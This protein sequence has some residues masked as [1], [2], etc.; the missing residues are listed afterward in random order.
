MKLKWK[1][2]LPVLALLLI[3]TLLTTLLNYSMTKSTV[4]KIVDSIVDSNLDTLNQMMNHA[5]DTEKAVSSELDSKNLALTR[6]FAEIVRLRAQRGGIDF[7]DTTLFQNIADMLGVDE[8]HVM[9]D[10]GVIV[11]SNVGIYYG[12]D[13]HSG[14]QT[15]PFLRILD[16]PSYELAQEPQPNASY[17]SLF[18]YTGVARTDEKGIVQVGIGA[19]MIEKLHNYLDIANT[20]AGMRIGSTG[21][22]VIIE[23]GTVMYSHKKDLIGLDVSK[24]DWYKQVSS[25]SGKKWMDVAGENVYAGFNNVGG[26]SLL[27]LYPRTE[28]NSSLSSVTSGAII[29]VAVMLLIP[30]IIYFLVANMLKPLIPLTGF[31]HK[32]SK[33]GDFTLS[34]DTTGSIKNNKDEIGE[35]RNAVAAFVGRISEVSQK[36]ESVADGDLTTEI[37]TLS[38]NDTLGFSLNKMSGKLNTMF[39]EINSS[40]NQVLHGSR[41]IAQGSQV[42]AQGSTEQAASIEELSSSIAEIAQKTKENAETAGNTAKLADTIRGNA[43][44]GSQQMD[45][46][47]NAV[48]DINQ[49]SQNINKVIKVIDDI[50]FQ[51]NILALNAAV[52]AAR[53]GQ[54]G[55]GFAVVAEEVRNLASKSAEAAKD[56]SAM[57]EDSMRK[58]ELGARIAG[59]TATSLAEIV[60]GI[61]ESTISINE[62]SKSSEEQSIGISQINVGIDQVAQVIQQNSATAEESAAASDEMSA[63]SGLLQELISQFKLNEANSRAS[64]PPA[65]YARLNRPMAI[66]NTELSFTDNYDKY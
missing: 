58:A 53:A 45:E 61:N 55:K 15:I 43:E 30:I 47:I 46:M 41:Q 34:S 59:E 26:T 21:N 27:V 12:F 52:E 44:K 37:V 31:M 39:G 60:A 65:G 48:K 28:Y 62:I 9:D 17:G 10:G 19:E 14:D 38:D 5:A 57:I 64:L 29:G 66:G 63:Q 13:F 3:S 51:T 2:A 16:D 24:E 36:L 35:L 1:I 42:L 7:D 56:T 20:A 25:G 40:A 50:A 18:Q 6:A 22:V 32:A 49:S 11:G 54:H 4:D 8:V 23:N 33:T